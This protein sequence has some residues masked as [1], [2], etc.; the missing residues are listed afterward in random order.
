TT[1]LTHGLPGATVLQEAIDQVRA[2]RGGNEDDAILTFNSAH[3]ALKE[4]MKRASELAAGL[5][6]PRL[7]D[8]KRARTALDHHWAFLDQEADLPEGLRPKAEALSDMMA[9]ETFYRDLVQIDQHATAIETEYQARF[10]AAA[11]AR[12]ECYQQALAT[13]H[14]NAAWAELNEEQQTRVAAPLASRA[15]ARVPLSATI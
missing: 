2:I 14:A 5:T 4:A 15:S 11:A 1:L 3:K 10:Q 6:E 13:L 9:R 7:F 8:L 12:T